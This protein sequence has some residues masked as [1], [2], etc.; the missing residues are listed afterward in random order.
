MEHDQLK[1][2]EHPSLH[3]EI[4]PLRQ[5]L[6]SATWFL[7]PPCSPFPVGGRAMGA[8][9]AASAASN[10]SVSLDDSMADPV[11]SEHPWLA[12]RTGSFDLPAW[13]EHVKLTGEGFG[14]QLCRTEV[15]NPN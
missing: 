1:G 12:L 13:H 4:E 9:L 7:L 8:K 11:A 2:V 6:F 10:I 3:Q 14:A 5:D 15:L